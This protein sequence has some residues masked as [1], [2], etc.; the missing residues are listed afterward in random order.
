M[1]E[2]FLLISIIAAYF[3]VDYSLSKVERFEQFESVEC[4]DIIDKLKY[5][6]MNVFYNELLKEPLEILKEP[7][8]LQNIEKNPSNSS[9]KTMDECKELSNITFLNVD[10]KKA[11]A[12]I[13]RDFKSLD[14]DPLKPFLDYC[15]KNKLK[16]NRKKLDILV[17]DCAI[18]SLK[19][20]NIFN[21]PRPYQLCSFYGF[22]INYLKSSHS[23]TP[24]YPSSFA[25]QSYVL[26]YV[27]GSK[28][29]KNQKDIEEIT[30]KISM[31]RVY[32]GNN[33]VSDVECSKAIMFNLRGY[34]DTI[35]I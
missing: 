10:N 16:V 3:I 28:H 27:I 14:T 31:S 11:I 5:G 23:D 15:D 26:G 24:S 6:Y 33:F 34:L 25:L 13:R 20:K 17:K 7:L 22:P 4:N 18:I 12:E 8:P 35:E 9:K 29:P 19:L 1:R 32:S 2:V 30:N 21:R